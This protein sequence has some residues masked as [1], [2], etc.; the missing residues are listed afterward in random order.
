MVQ[1]GKREQLIVEVCLINSWSGRELTRMT[2]QVWNL[3]TRICVFNLHSVFKV[4]GFMPNS[5]YYNFHRFLCINLCSVLQVLT[6]E[7]CV[8]TPYLPQGI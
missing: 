6:D 2:V 5:I 3:K 8:S 4:N 7:L 1:V